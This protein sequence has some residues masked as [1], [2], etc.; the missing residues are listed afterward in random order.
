MTAMDAQAV[1]MFACV[2]DALMD[3]PSKAAAMRMRSDLLSAICDM[4][5]GWNVSR[6]V[7]AQ[8]LDLT[9]PRLD[10]LLRGSVGWFSIDE[11]IGLAT[12]AGLDVRVQA[13]PAGAGRT[14]TWPR[15][16][17]VWWTG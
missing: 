11:L 10:E 1:Q 2:W 13:R 12:R 14:A 3:A 5:A 6:A 4:V 8:R 17:R 9:G 15:P 7:V 16:S